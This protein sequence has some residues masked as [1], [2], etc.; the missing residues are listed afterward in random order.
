VD[1]G[2]ADVQIAEGRRVGFGAVFL[3]LLS[4]V[5]RGVVSRVSLPKLMN[6]VLVG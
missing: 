1:D 4:H 3:C 6:E 5:V 2:G